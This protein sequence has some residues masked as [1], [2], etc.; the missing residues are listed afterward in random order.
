VYLTDGGS[1]EVLD[2]EL[3]WSIA[4]YLERGQGREAKYRIWAD[5]HRPIQGRLHSTSTAQNGA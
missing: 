2:P 4:A 1:R 3:S 5:G